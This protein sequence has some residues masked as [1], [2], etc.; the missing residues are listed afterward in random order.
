MKM[1]S[2][3]VIVVVLLIASCTTPR[4]AFISPDRWAHPVPLNRPLT[5][6]EWA[7]RNHPDLARAKMMPKFL[8]DELLH[9][10]DRYSDAWYRHRDYELHRRLVEIDEQKMRLYRQRTEDQAP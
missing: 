7:E 9:Q 5:M 1:A 10:Y 6:P 2:K 3:T 4:T 8:K